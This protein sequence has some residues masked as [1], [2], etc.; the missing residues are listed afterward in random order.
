M[1][2]ISKHS[3]E[4]NKQ[5]FKRKGGGGRGGG[6]GGKSGGGSSGGGRSTPVS[7]GGT[8]KSATVGGNGGG[9]PITLS[10][11]PF[12]GTQAGGGTRSQVYGSRYMRFPVSLFFNATI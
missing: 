10:S 11:G 6:G 4:S 5:L 2:F 1:P 8:S 9:A 12:A 3:P 7:V